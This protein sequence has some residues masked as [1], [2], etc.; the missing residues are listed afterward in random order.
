VEVSRYRPL[1][2]GW[3][4]LLVAG[5]CVALAAIVGNWDWIRFALECGTGAGVAVVID[6]FTPRT[7]LFKKLDEV[8]PLPV[9][10][11]DVSDS[12]RDVLVVAVSL[13]ATYLATTAVAVLLFRENAA[14]ILAIMAGVA[15]GFTVRAARD[16]RMLERWEADNGR[17]FAE[18][19]WG[20]K[21]K[22]HLYVE[23]PAVAPLDAR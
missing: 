19:R 5:V 8:E 1:T 11:L 20:V 14:A 13:L 7:S 9:G 15:A 2:L 17:L 16:S 23:D 18:R 4:G 6:R 10:A 12:E 21:R 3:A 22:S